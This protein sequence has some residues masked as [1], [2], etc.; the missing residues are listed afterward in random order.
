M[1]VEKKSR[2]TTIYIYTYTNTLAVIRLPLKA[3][4]E[5]EKKNL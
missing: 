5:K 2:Q 3:F 4:K 1:T